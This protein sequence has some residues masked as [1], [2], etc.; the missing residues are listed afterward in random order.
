MEISGV[1]SAVFIGAA[2]G[3]LGRL[4]LPGRQHIGVL[5]TFVVGVAA[6]LLGSLL[7]S[8]SGVAATR[9]VDWIEWLLQIVLAGL[10]VAALDRALAGTE[11]KPR[12]RE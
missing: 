2:V 10:G 5:W 8:L 6:A 4:V 1:V 7:A 3:L 12:L 9:G 11:R